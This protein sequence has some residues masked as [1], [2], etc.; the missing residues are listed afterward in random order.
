MNVVTRSL[1]VAGLFVYAAIHF[2]Q[3]AQPPASAPA[4]LQWAFVATA[5]AAIGLGLGLLLRPPGQNRLWKDAAAALAAGSAVALFLSAT[6]GFFGVE[7]TDISA[8]VF[9]VAAAELVVLASWL[10]DRSVGP[11][12]NEVDG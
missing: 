8:G 11:E 4:W 10:A 6:T 3:A 5:V 9:G 1:M 2:L 12:F 7:G